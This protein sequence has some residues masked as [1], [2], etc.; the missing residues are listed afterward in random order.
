MK[1]NPENPGIRLKV[2]FLNESMPNCNTCGE[3]CEMYLKKD[4]D[5]NIIQMC[6]CAIDALGM[7]SVD[8]VREH[9]CE[10]YFTEPEE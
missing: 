4:K 8:Y 6:L 1:D 2:R 9:G 7:V 3:V 5:G 10:H